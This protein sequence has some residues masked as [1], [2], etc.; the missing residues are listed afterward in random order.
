[1]TALAGAADHRPGEQAEMSRQERV[2]RVLVELADTLVAG[3]DVIDFLHTLVERS[4][5]LLAADAAGLMLADQQGRLEV[6]AAS[7]EE[8]RVLE[9]FEL[10]SSQGPCMDCFLSGEP[11]VN[12]DVAQQADRWPLFVRAASK[13]G[14]RNAHALPLRLR[15]QVIGA[16]NLFSVAPI[17]LSAAD[18]AL[19]QGMADIATIGLLQQRR[20]LERDILTEQLQAA[21]NTRIVIEQAKGVLSERAGIPLGTAFTLMRSRARSTQQPLTAIAYGVLDGSINTADLRPK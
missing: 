17:P 5:E 6:V 2:T 9:L 14:Y 21:L 20:A 4:V 16:M 8:A 11:L 12:I 13:A 7:A 1:M 18:I 3:F 15:G 10:Q 19:G